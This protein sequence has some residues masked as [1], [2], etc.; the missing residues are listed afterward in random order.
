MEFTYN[1]FG[2]APKFAADNRRI[3]K[4]NWLAHLQSIKSVYVTTATGKTFYGRE[5][6]GILRGFVRQL[7]K[8][9]ADIPAAK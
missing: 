6:K 9:T 3:L 7:E 8:A 1:P 2:D 5:S 4:E